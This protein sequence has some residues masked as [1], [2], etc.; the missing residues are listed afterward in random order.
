M[1]VIYSILDPV[2]L[3]AWRTTSTRLHTIVKCV[4]RVQSG[5][6]YVYIVLVFL[7]THQIG[8]VYSTQYLI[9]MVLYEH[10]G[11]VQT[12]GCCTRCPMG[13]KGARS[14]ARERSPLAGFSVGCLISQFSFHERGIFYPKAN[15]MSASATGQAKTKLAAA[16]AGGGRKSRSTASNTAPRGKQ[17]T[18]ADGAAGNRT[19][20][21]TI[22][23]AGSRSI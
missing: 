1:M 20:A 18:H 16:E 22:A 17:P 21:S 14:N 10:R 8:L 9:H 5:F 15:H 7:Y 3:L 4:Q 12:Q 2:R 13:K 11:L 6:W 19:A 23:T